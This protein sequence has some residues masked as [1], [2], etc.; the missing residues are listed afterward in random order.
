[1]ALPTIK[2]NNTSGSNTA[3]SGAGP[4]TALTGTGAYSGD[5]LGGGTQTVIDLSADT[6]NLSGVAVDGSAALWLGNAAGERHLFRITAVDDVAD[7]VTVHVAP[8]TAIASASPVSWAIGGKR[9]DFEGDTTNCDWAD[10][11]AG[12]TYQLDDDETYAVTVEIN[13]PLANNGAAP[14]V[15]RRSGG[16]TNKPVLDITTSIRI[17]NILTASASIEVDGLKGTRSAGSWVGSAFFR[18]AAASV[19]LAVRNCDVDSSNMGWGIDINSTCKFQLDNLNISN[20]DGAGINIGT[21]RPTGSIRR[22]SVHNCTGTGINIS[23]PSSYVASSVM[24]CLIYNNGGAGI[25]VGAL[26]TTHYW[27][28]ILRNTIYGNTGDGLEITAAPNATATIEIEGNSFAQNGGYGVNAHATT[29]LAKVL[30][31]RNNHYF[32]N[33]S[34]ARLNLAAGAGDVSGDPLFSSVTPG[35][36]DF[37]PGA[38]STLIGAGPVVPTA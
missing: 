7:T 25:S 10:P 26:S 27:S 28:S 11:E 23:S 15:F 30:I 5:G 9:K 36:E 2:Y 32:G 17:F 29:A 37:T 20:I 1:M 22:C 35:S 38:G 19:L 4:A 21:S 6:P 16:G 8:T 34:G 3:A 13:P 24:D 18:S 12:W 14:V 33:T 31:N